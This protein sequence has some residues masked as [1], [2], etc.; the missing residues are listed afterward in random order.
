MTYSRLLLVA[1]GAVGCALV[2]MIALV[3]GF[4]SSPVAVI[5]I[6]S[7]S[8]EQQ[9]FVNAVDVSRK[10]YQ[11]APND[12]AKG[13][14]RSERKQLIDAA[15]RSYMVSGWIGRVYALSSN[16]DGK[17][18]LALRI[19]P[20][21]YLKTWNNAVSDI[22]DQTLIDQSS[23]V[24][25]AASRMTPGDVARF[26][27]EFFKSDVDTVREASLSIGGSMMRPEFIFRFTDIEPFTDRGS[28][29][30]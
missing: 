16:S 20:E 27:G 6:S 12:M 3:R 1:I 11:G 9:A 14:A 24:F 19:G 5:N 10:M 28:G 8:A 13:A 15:L 26:S 4:G 30:K 17:G 7:L 22:G 18:V 25:R 23:S 2:I 29:M 21:M